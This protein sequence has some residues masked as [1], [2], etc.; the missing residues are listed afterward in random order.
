[1]SSNIQGMANSK[2]GNT[3]RS[4]ISQSST[5]YK[6]ND[7]AMYSSSLSHQPIRRRSSWTRAELYPRPA[8]RFPHTQ[9]AAHLQPRTVVQLLFRD[10][11]R[12]KCS[13]HRRG[14]FMVLIQT[15]LVSSAL[16]DLP[17]LSCSVLRVSPALFADP[18]NVRTAWS[19]TLSRQKLK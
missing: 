2:A 18:A 1:M 9:R 6:S 12:I 11:L 14:T 4:R 7:A 5:L 15:L 19:C 16:P 8:N 10:A 3:R 13:D 17:A